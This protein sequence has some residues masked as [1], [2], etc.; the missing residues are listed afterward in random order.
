MGLNLFCTTVLLNTDRSAVFY[1]TFPYSP[2]QPSETS[3]EERADDVVVAG[4]KLSILV[5]TVGL[6][7]LLAGR[8]NAFPNSGPTITSDPTLAT[9]QQE[10]L[11]HARSRT[12]NVWHV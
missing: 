7:A 12:H 4:R 5:R 3:I 2:S 1:S 6:A 10:L 11:P 9:G 8:V